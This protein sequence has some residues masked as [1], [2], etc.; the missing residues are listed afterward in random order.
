LY[1]YSANNPIS[2][3]DPSGLCPP[4]KQP[5][6]GDIAGGLKN[7]FRGMAGARPLGYEQDFAHFPFSFSTAPAGFGVIQAHGA[8]GNSQL[9]D[10]FGNPVYSD[11]YQGQIG[12]IATVIKACN[13]GVCIDGVSAA[14][15][16]AKANGVWT[17]G[18]VGEVSPIDPL[19]PFFTPSAILFDPNGNFVRSFSWPMLPA[20]WNTIKSYATSDLFK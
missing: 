10:M 17:V 19:N 20:D 5:R 8:A 3:I 7:M 12:T 15:A 11:Q 16:F 2:V 9:T 4:E 1:G 6:N 13:S 14:G 18:Y